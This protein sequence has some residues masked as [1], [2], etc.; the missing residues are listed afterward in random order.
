M[1]HF[2]EETIKM[3][4]KHALSKTCLSCF[5]EGKSYGISNK[6]MEFSEHPVYLRTIIVTK[7]II[8]L[9]SS[10]SVFYH[11]EVFEDLLNLKKKLLG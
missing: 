2:G 9:S 1:L 7:I 4:L 10:W 6:D 11:P 3:K 5:K 8:L